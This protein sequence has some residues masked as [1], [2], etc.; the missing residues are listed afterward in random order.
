MAPALVPAM[1][2]IGILFS[3]SIFMTPIW[4]KPFGPPPPN[5]N[6]IF[7]LNME[8]LYINSSTKFKFSK[9]GRIIFDLN[10]DLEFE[11]TQS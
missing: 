7:G 5:A 2:S 6:P 8:S 9:T 3:S 4:A 1:K 10:F 11:F